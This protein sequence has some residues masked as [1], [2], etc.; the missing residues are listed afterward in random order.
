[1]PPSLEH[2]ARLAV[3]RVSREEHEILTGE[4][5]HRLLR[6]R[7]RE[8][9]VAVGAKAH[10][11][12]HR[13]HETTRDQRHRAFHRF[14]RPD[15]LRRPPSLERELLEQRDVDVRPNA[16]SEDARSSALIRCLRCNP[17]TAR[18]SFKA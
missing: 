5:I 17:S 3:P 7:P 10:V 11:G 16:E 13:I 15:E 18:V 4:E 2:D 8:P 6:Q 12:E 14:F 9:H 1:M